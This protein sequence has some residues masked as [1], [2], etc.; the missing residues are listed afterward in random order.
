MFWDFLFE[1][2]F[3]VQD[4]EAKRSNPNSI[5]SSTKFYLSAFFVSF[6]LSKVHL[7]QDH[8][9]KQSNQYKKSS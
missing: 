2:G 3:L 9:A 4:H 7:T 1:Q 5:K 6:S 8:E